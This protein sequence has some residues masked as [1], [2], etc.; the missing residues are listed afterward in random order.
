MKSAKPKVLD[1]NDKSRLNNSTEIQTAVK[2][3]NQF[4]RPDQLRSDT[5][6]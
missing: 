3:I 5:P 4:S 1:E 2:I 6:S